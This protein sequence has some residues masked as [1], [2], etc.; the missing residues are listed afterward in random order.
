MRGHGGP[1][2]GAGPFFRPQGGCGLARLLITPGTRDAGGAAAVDARGSVTVTARTRRG[3]GGAATASSRAAGRRWAIL[4]ALGWLV[5]VGLRVWFSRHQVMPL[6]NPD[7]TAYLVTARVLAGG[8]AADLSDSTLY[9]GGYPL[10]IT[11]AA[12]CRPAQRARGRADRGGRGGRRV[13]AEPP[14][15]PACLPGGHP[16]PVW[17]DLAA[18]GQRERQHPRARDG[19]GPAMADGARQLGHRGHRPGRRAAGD[20]APRRAERPADHGRARD[21]GDHAHRLHGPGRTALRPGAGLGVR[22]LPGRHDRRVLAG[23]RRGAAPGFSCWP[24]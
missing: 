19:G 8:P 23:R 16:Q 5:Q 20:R 21:R 13:G 3:A 4:L 11:L 1:G 12:G 18:A 6:A 22:A 10:L 17:P 15:Q 24:R 7:E 9:P 2:G 14:H